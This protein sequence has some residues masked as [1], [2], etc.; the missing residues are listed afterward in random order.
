MDVNKNDLRPYKD[1]TQTE[2]RMAGVVV[3]P[4]A[5]N[6]LAGYTPGHRISI[7]PA[8][9]AGVDFNVSSPSEQVLII[10]TEDGGQRQVPVT[11]KA[12]RLLQFHNQAK[13][14]K[15]AKPITYEEAVLMAEK[16]SDAEVDRL[17]PPA[18]TEKTAAAMPAPAAQSPSTAQP[19]PL[20]AAPAPVPRKKI[21]VKISGA[22]GAFTVPFDEVFVHGIF[23]VLIQYD[24]EEA[25]FEAPSSQDHVRIDVLEKGLALMCLPGVQYPVE[26]QRAY[27]TV[28][29]VDEEKT[30]ELAND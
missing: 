20:T 7:P 5:C 11:R 24:N 16:M 25:S 22:F 3:P 23:L 15:P 4:A 27:H 28:Y 17:I 10:P 9:T 30:K 12:L 18:A 29:L 26:S 1:G 2:H 14:G 21:K 13:P 19:A 8:D 6:D